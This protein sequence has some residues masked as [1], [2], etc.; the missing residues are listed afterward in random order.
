MGQEKIG[1]I[2]ETAVK[3]MGAFGGGI[4]SSGNVCGILI[5][6]IATISSIYSRGNL[7][8]KENPRL[9]SASSKFLKKFE[10]LTSELGGINCCDIAKVDWKNKLEAK[11]YYVNPLS[12]RKVCIKLIGDTAYEL[13]KLIEKEAARD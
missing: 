4:A 10:E 7:D 12:S 6:G 13:G 11:N 9:W 1:E 8:E 3:A 2:D 5:G